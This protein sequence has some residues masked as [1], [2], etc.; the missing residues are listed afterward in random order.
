MRLLRK[1]DENLIVEAIRSAE[2]ATSGEVRVHIESRCEE[3][4]PLDRAA[5]IFQELGMEKTALRNGVLVYVALKSR[6]FCII[7]DAGINSVV[8]ADF[9]D[10]AKDLMLKEFAQGHIAQGIASGINRVGVLL[11]EKFPYQDDDV[12]ELPDAI[13]YGK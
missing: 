11:K 13:S 1:K 12:N 3:D 2:L 7:G 6:Q 4:N 10:S 5:W 8:P 9:W